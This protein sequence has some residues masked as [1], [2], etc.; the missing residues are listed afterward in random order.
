[1][2]IGA[3]GLRSVV[4]EGLPGAD[5]APPRY[6]GYSAWR[7]VL[8]FQS[9]ALPE[10][11]SCETWGR[12]R[13]F[14]YVPLGRG[15]V[16]WFATENTPHALGAAPPSKS[17]LLERFGDWHA[18]IPAL[19]E[20]TEEGV[21][22][23]NPIFDRDPAEVW[24][25]GRVTLLGDAVHP[26]TPNLGQGA[27]Q[28]IEDAVVLARCLAGQAE[29]EGALRA[30]EAARRKR[31]SE[32]TLLSRRFGS[33]AQ[34]SHPLVCRLRDTVMRMTPPRLLQKQLREIVGYQL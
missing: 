23:H 34:A 22:L 9:E 7:A 2:L 6:A 5:A 16:Y 20:A 32:I 21:I 25:E 11:Y 27:C 3:D 29:V 15:R 14:G 13:R 28:A 17:A 31:T 30:Y 33:M 24:G 10:G 1:V 26:T 19:L 4:R 8:P 18:P 12:G